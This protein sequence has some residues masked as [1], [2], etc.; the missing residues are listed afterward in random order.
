MGGKCYCFV[1]LLACNLLGFLKKD[2]Y[3]CVNKDR[4]LYEA[5]LYLIPVIYIYNGE[6][7]VYVM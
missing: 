3:L 6:L 1:R 4:M 5:Q 7:D 2:F